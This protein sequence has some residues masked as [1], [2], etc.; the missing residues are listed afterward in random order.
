MH[1]DSEYALEY[2][3]SLANDETVINISDN[4]NIVTCPPAIWLHQF[5]EITKDTNIKLGGQD[6]HFAMNGAFTGDIS[7]EMLKDAGCEYVIVGHSERRRAYGEDDIIVAHKANAALI[8]ELKPIICVGETK[9]Q[10]DNGEHIKAIQLQIRT[11]LSE[12]TPHHS[13]IIAYEPVWAIGT[14]HTPTTDEIAEMFDIIM[15]ECKRHGLYHINLLYGGSVRPENATELF[16]VKTL[17][18]LLVGNASTQLKQ[19]TEII[20]AAIR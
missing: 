2:M 5:L 4:L 9:L 16:Q 11:L 20:K 15:H 8:A 17:S 19:W 10:R 7:A 3:R 13:L 18:G 1:G 14:G 6:C 12:I